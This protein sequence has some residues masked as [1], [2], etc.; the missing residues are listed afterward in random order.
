MVKGKKG[1]VQN[2]ISLLPGHPDPATLLTAELHRAMLHA[3]NSPQL[4]TALQYG[5]ERGTQS[6]LDF[7]VGKITREQDVSLR[8]ENIIVVAGSTHA[9]DSSQHALHGP[10]LSQPDGPHAV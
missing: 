8:S 2:T 4:L 6:L 5:P 3:I 7:L 10:N 1:T 9:V